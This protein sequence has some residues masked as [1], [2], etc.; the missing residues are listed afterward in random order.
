MIVVQTFEVELAQ[1]QGPEGV[2]DQKLRNASSE[3]EP[4]RLFFPD[5]EPPELRST[6]QPIDVVQRHLSHRTSQDFRF[7]DDEHEVVVSIPVEAE[8]LL[9][10]FGSNRIGHQ[11]PAPDL[12]LIA[13]GPRERKIPLFE[14][15]QAS[16]FS[17][18]RRDVTLHHT[19][20]PAATIDASAS[21][22]RWT[23]SRS[24]CKCMGSEIS[25]RLAR[26]ETG[27]AG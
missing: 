16:P 19:R 8:P 17:S 21:H 12:I 13:P 15:S 5:H 9:M 6:A 26:R 22:T 3:T 1:S 11:K 27:H 7:L 24:S 4:A 20:R 14:Q 2:V 25:R 18:E 10:L 23:S